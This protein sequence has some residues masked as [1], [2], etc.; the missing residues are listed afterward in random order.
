MQSILGEAVWKN[1]P[2]LCPQLRLPPYR[3]LPGKN[4]H[5]G[6]DHLPPLGDHAIHYGIDL[7]HAGYFYE[8]HEAWEP[9]WLRLPPGDLQRTLLHGLIQLTAALLKIELGQWRPAQTLSRRAYHYIGVVQHRDPQLLQLDLTQLSSH[10][11]RYF[12]SLWAG[13]SQ[14]ASLMVS[15]AP[16]LQ[17]ILK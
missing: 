4:L 15:R 14:G 12:Q 6:E 2:R 17:L 5:P 9:L 13:A 3:Y 7:Y 1:A 16:R 10:I 8:A 11:Q